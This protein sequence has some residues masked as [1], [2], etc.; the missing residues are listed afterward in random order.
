VLVLTNRTNVAFDAKSIC[1]N[2]VLTM[3]ISTQSVLKIP[4]KCAVLTRTVEISK[5]S[6]S[7]GFSHDMSVKTV[8]K[9]LIHNIHNWNE[10][11]DD[12][13]EFNSKLSRTN[14]TFDENTNATSRLL[15]KVQIDAFSRTETLLIASSSSLTVLVVLIVAIALVICMYK[16]CK[17]NDRRKRDPIVVVVDKAG[18]DLRNAELANDDL[19]KERLNA[20]VS[21]ENV[22]RDDESALK[23]KTDFSEM[24]P[25]FQRKM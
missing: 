19:V 22:T 20:N 25:P 6:L 23:N 24:R 5:S 7:V 11:K 4:E 2:E 10:K 16:K 3:Q 1:M 18:N 14:S 21:K 15:N 17:K 13:Q 9:I 12:F 8:E